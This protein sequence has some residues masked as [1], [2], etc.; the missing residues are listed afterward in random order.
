VHVKLLYAL[1][2]DRHTR[3]KSTAHAVR[4]LCRPQEWLKNVFVLAPL[5]FSGALRHRAAVAAALAAV[6]CFCL[7]SS[8]MYCFND[9]LDAAA[10]RC[11][12]RKRLRP[13]AAGRLARAWALVLSAGLALVASVAAWALLPLP[14]VI[15]GMCYLA[16]AVL[17]TLVLKHR[18][19]VDV[20]SIA[21]GFVMRLLAGCVAIAVA[22]SA[23]LAVCGF[24]LAMLLGFGKRRLEIAHVLVGAAFRPALMAYTVAKLNLLLGVTASL[25][26]LSYTLYTV[27]PTTIERHG[28]NR[29]VYTVPLVAYGIWRYVRKG[30]EGQHDGPIEVLLADWIFPT[31]IVLWLLLVLMLIY[32]KRLL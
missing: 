13:V 10:D 18:A 8:A 28:T 30:Q 29:M 26:L 3:G 19:I 23:W 21:L 15:A 14:F 24:S 32:G 11:H 4:Q 5:L 27:A 17:Y 1:A 16:N 12:P 22:P 6:G 9:V 2:V 20:L 25:C 31:T 7:W